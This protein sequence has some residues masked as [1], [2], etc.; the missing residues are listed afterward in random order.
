MIRFLPLNLYFHVYETVTRKGML[1]ALLTIE[2]RF[3]QQKNSIGKAA[4]VQSVHG[5][6]ARPICVCTTGG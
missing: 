4:V 6:A 3:G 5:D 2:N 1:W